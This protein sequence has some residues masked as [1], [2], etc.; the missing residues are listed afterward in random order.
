MNLTETKLDFD[1]IKKQLIEH[2]KDN[3][4]GDFTDWDFEGSNLNAIMDLLAYNTH[5]NAVTAHMAVNESFIDSAQLRSSVVSAAKL[6][7]YVP[8]SSTA[9]TIRLLGSFTLKNN[10]NDQPNIVKIPH[11]TRFTTTFEND[12]RTFVTFSRY[13]ND[14]IVEWDTTRQLYII[15]KDNPI[16]AYEGSIETETYKTVRGGRYVI[17]A[18]NVDISKINVVV[19]YDNKPVVYTRY[20]NV[21]DILDGHTYMINENSSGFYEITLND[22]M[23]SDELSTPTVYGG[24]MTIEYLKTR[25][26]DGNGVNGANFSV[27]FPASSIKSN[28]FYI[29]SGKYI[30]VVPGDRS[31][32][33]SDKEEI[34]RIKANAVESFRAQ[35]RAVTASDYRSLILKNFP[36]IQSVS[37][38]GGEDNTPPEYGKIFIAAKQY[39]AASDAGQMLVQLSPTD[40]QQIIRFLNDKKVL[41]LTPVIVDAEQMNLVLDILVKYDPRIT[42]FDNF[43]L[44]NYIREKVVHYHNLTDLNTF[45][46]EFKYSSFLHLVDASNVAITNSY[47]R[48]YLKQTMSISGDTTAIRRNSITRL[49]YGAPLDVVDGKCIVHHSTN[50]PWLIHGRTVTIKDE[51]SD[52]TGY[53]DVYL[54]IDDG[55]GNNNMIK[56]KKI[57]VIDLANGIL[58]MENLRSDKNLNLSITLNPA[59]NDILSTHNK[60]LSIDEVSTTIKAFPISSIQEGFN[61][62]R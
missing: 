42:P 37:V 14:N 46:A 60:L 15:P 21:T 44:E 53:R 31:A 13:I 49:D 27:T 17:P 32:G 22:N 56:N 12:T 35:N 45:G 5:F 38:W 33:G 3:P 18:K 19:E 8:K 1:S 7:G 11:G 30:A 57:G 28:D 61:K 26:E 43:E 50:F 9:A 62:V 47:V 2:F 29:S 4:S 48:V 58:T 59:S 51:P 24:T 34:E 55:R 25:G 10:K 52:R 41:T 6:L 54:Y 39:D 23:S 40:R 36:M 20:E 16:I